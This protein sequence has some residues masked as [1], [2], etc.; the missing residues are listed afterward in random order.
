[1]ILSTGMYNVVN[2]KT[3]EMMVS[4][5]PNTSA[6][7]GYVQNA[8]NSII[9]GGGS[10]FIAIAMFF[11]A[12]T[13]L[14]AF[15]FFVEV[16]VDFF[17]RNSKHRTL[18]LN[19][20]RIVTAFFTF[21]GALRDPGAAWNLADLGVGLLVWTN[22]AGVLLLS[23]TFIKLFKDYE[24]QKKLGLDPVFDPDRLGIKGVD[25][26]KDIIKE[27]YSDLLEARDKAEGKAKEIEEVSLTNDRR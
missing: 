7:A 2:E 8:I 9:P 10:W 23:N 3:G 12:F 22:L 17:A 20:L 14:I 5:I 4:N 27:K 21:M 19:I 6:G 15:A 1:M 11:F 25:L 16:N 18:I 13:T 24:Q 26:W